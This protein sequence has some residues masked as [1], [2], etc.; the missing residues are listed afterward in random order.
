MAD[1]FPTAN[2][3]VA[4]VHLGQESGDLARIVLQ[5][6]VERH[7]QLTSSPSKPGA[8][9]SRLAEVPPKSHP[10]N[11]RVP[12]R[13]SFDHRPRPVRRAVVNQDHI[14]LIAFGRRHLAEFTQ[15]SFEALFFIEDGNH[16]REHRDGSSTFRPTGA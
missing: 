9:R 11:S 7:D 6:G 3:I 15:Q 12:G 2:H 8:Q 10:A 4:L 1:L 16:N 13:Q 5:I 14:Q